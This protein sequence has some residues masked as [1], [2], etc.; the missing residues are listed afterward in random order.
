[1]EENS[2][3]D[4]DDYNNNTSNVNPECSWNNKKSLQ[5]HRPCDS[6]TKSPSAKKMKFSK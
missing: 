5:D 4:D 1:M 3:D 6:K 2:D